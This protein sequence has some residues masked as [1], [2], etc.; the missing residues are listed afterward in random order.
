MDPLLT[1]VHIML[2]NLS[3]SAFTIVQLACSQY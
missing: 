3:L 1:V 2:A